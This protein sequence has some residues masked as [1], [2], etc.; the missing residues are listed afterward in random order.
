MSGFINQY[1]PPV[2]LIA[3]G[4]DPTGSAGLIADIRVISSLGC[5]PAGVTT[6]QTV[7]SSRGVLSIVPA[8]PVLLSDQIETLLSDLPVNALKIGAI[9]SAETLDVLSRFLRKFPSIP[10]I[11]DPVFTSTSG[12][13]FFD[14]KMLRVFGESILKYTLIA[15]P[16]IRELAAFAG[17]EPDPS[18]DSEILGASNLWLSTGLKNILVTGLK[19]GNMIVDRLL[20][21]SGYEDIAHEYHD[22]GEVHGTGCVLSSAI[23]ARIAHGD[24]I[25]DACGFA[26]K[27]TS[28][29]IKNARRFGEGASF[30]IG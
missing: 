5:H 11:A 14:D 3:S 6:C 19:R 23:A 25:K 20:T 12:H 26:I 1:S 8:D 10:V 30:W 16:N 17:A 9:S 29:A 27:F 4:L 21:M 18:S 22:V 28:D 7:Q 13:R 15:T 24:N 2:V